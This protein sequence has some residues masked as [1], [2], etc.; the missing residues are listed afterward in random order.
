MPRSGATPN[1][2]LRPRPEGP[3]FTLEWPAAWEAWYYRSFYPDTWTDIPHLDPELPLLV[4]GGENSDTFTAESAALVREALA[5]GH[6]HHRVRGRAPLSPEPSRGNPGHS[7]RLA[8]GAGLIP[9][10]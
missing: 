2:M 6:A 1:S 10:S 7:R 5:P 4:V 8:G 3:G 9:V